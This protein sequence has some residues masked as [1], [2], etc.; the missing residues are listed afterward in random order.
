M[1]KELARVM[2]SYKQLSA[3]AG[4]LLSELKDHEHDYI[5]MRDGVFAVAEELAKR[6]KA[7][8]APNAADPR[9][10]KDPHVQD[11]LEDLEKFKTLMADRDAFY[12]A[13][14]KKVDV[15]RS[16]ALKLEKDVQ[17]VIKAKSGFFSRS[18]SLP[19]LKALSTNLHKFADDLETATTAI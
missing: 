17:A 10:A 16:D 13:V 3:K 12:R 18:K 15:V 11:L 8:G 19:Q 14:S 4:P 1:P 2:T 9:A 6:L 7:L 5:I